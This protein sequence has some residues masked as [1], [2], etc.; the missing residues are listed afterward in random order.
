MTSSLVQEWAKKYY[1]D[2]LYPGIIESKKSE[3]KVWDVGSEPFPVYLLWNIPEANDDVTSLYFRFPHVNNAGRVYTVYSV[4][5]VGIMDSDGAC[6][7]SRKIRIATKS[8]QTHFVE[9][10]KN[11]I[12]TLLDQ[13]HNKK[14]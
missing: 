11:A 1:H 9:E 7:S 13:F 4:I 2:V 12:V 14:L 5:D 3:W 6:L 8:S 10:I